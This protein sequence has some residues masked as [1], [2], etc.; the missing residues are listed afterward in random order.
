MKS[1]A[2]LLLFGLTA[3]AQQNPRVLEGS[4]VNSV[5]GL[6]IDGA[7]ITL[8]SQGKGGIGVKNSVTDAAGNFHISGLA[9][10]NYRV[11]AEKTGLT[12][13]SVPSLHIDAATDPARL[14]FEMIPHAILRGHVFGVDGKPAAKVPV[15]LGPQYATKT[16]TG[17]DGAFVFENVPPGRV[18]LV[19]FDGHVR[20]YFPAAT[21]AASG[22][23][24]TVRPGEDQ[25]GYEI[26]L[27]TAN[28][29]RIRGVV[30][31]RAGKPSAGSIVSLSPG[32]A[33]YAGDS[34]RVVSRRD[35]DV[36]VE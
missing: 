8:M 3:L 2:T 11:F 4:V 27:Q 18:S 35:Y 28:V 12:T 29:Y 24:I 10:G 33:Q 1:V 30:L 13:P 36:Q 7:K 34:I 14:R 9:P 5:T 25:G 20:T 15:A 19:A 16:L 17:D 31:D 26:R 23:S 21:D 32:S 22:E 6:G